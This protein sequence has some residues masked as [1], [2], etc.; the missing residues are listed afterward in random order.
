MIKI[1]IPK[2]DVFILKQ[3]QLGDI[4]EPKLSSIYGFTDYRK[5]PRDVAG[6]YMF[7]N[8]NGELLYCG[9]TVKLRQRIRSHFNGTTVINFNLDEVYK[10][11]VFFVPDALDREIYESYII[12]KLEAKYNIDKV[13]FRKVEPLPNSNNHN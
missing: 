2:T 10:I 4:S 8:K 11:A 7:F 3:K 1:V 13:F 12:N 5:I 9:Q 6:I